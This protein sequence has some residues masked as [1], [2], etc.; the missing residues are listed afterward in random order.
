M[1][2]AANILPRT[3]EC[4][5][6]RSFMFSTPILGAAVRGFVKAAA[7]CDVT[8]PEWGRHPRQQQP[9]QYISGAA[10][11]VTAAAAAAAPAAMAAAAAAVAVAAAAAVKLAAGV[12]EAAVAAMTAVAAAASGMFK[13]RV[14]ERAMEAKRA[15]AMGALA[16]WLQQ[17]DLLP[18]LS[19]MIVLEWIAG[20]CMNWCVVAPMRQEISAQIASR[21]VPCH[22]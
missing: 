6:A 2:R 14:V 4:E 5:T 1:V 11:A 12:G 22:A 9:Q 8:V 20:C 17:Q 13:C 18:G 15:A 21:A 7:A 19:K 10:A 3:P 16:A